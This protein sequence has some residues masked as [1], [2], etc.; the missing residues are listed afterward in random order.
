MLYVKNKESPEKINTII[1][2]VES[3]ADS[4]FTDNTTPLSY[5]ND[6]IFISVALK[7]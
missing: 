4:T 2:T 5:Y 1:S 3:K 7:T 6:T